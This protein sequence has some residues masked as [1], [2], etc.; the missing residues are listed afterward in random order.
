VDGDQTADASEAQIRPLP[1]GSDVRKVSASDLPRVVEALA[2][3]FYDDPIFSWV[4]PDDARRVGK[5]ERGFDLFARR[6]WFPH[7]EAYTTDRLIG[8]AFWM[9]PG[10]WHLGLLAQLRLLPMMAVI[11]RRD[12]PRLLGVLNAIET[13]HPHDHHYY[14]PLVGIAPDWQ[15]RGFGSALLRPMLER[16]DRESVPAYLEATSPRNRALY[17][18]HGFTVVEELRVKDSPPLWRMWRSPRP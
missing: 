17:E 11:T 4:A 13:K 5:L 9:P 7:D 1:D 8:A 12:L 10:T 2:R 18:R 16:C 3:S 6:V 15:G 14:L